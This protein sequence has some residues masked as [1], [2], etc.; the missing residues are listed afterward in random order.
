MST[1]ITA[2]GGMF[3][4]FGTDSLPRWCT[5]TVDSRSKISRPRNKHKY[6]NLEKK[7]FKQKIVK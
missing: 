7:H 4:Y 2:F 3:T 1:R 5:E 6:K